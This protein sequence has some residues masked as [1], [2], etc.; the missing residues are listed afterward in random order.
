MKKQNLIFSVLSALM[1]CGQADALTITKATGWLESA[2]LTWQPVEN[3]EKYCVWYTDETAVARQIDMPLIRCYGAYYRADILGLKAGEYLFTVKAVDE[4]GNELESAV[5]APVAVLPHVREGFAF[6]DG[7]AEMVPGAYGSDGT[8]KP[9][10][11]VIYISAATVNTVTCDVINERGEAVPVTGL[12]NILSAR[13]RG[14][15]KTPLAIRMIGL[16]KS[17]QIDGLKG[18]NYIAFIGSNADKRMI[19]NITFEGVGNDATAYGYGFFTKRSKG[20]EIRNV[21][22]M[23][24]G[25]DGVSMEGDNFN[26]W[27]HNNDF[28]YGAPGSDKDQVKGDGSI[29]MKYNTTNITVSFNH[30]WDSGKTTFAGGAT[31]ENPIYFTYH[32]NWFDHSDSRHPRLCHATAHIYNN[33]FDGNKTMCLLNT[34]NSSAFV[35]ANHYRNCPY[36]MMINMQGTNRVIWPDGTQNGGMTKA[37]NNKIEGACTLVYQTDNADDFDAYLV[38]S[39]DEQIPAAVRSVTGGNV[40]S[41]FDTA[42]DMYA[43]TADDPEQVRTVVMAYAGRVEGGDLKWNFDND[44]DDVLTEVNT[45]LKDA[46]VGYESTLVSIQEEDAAGGSDPGEG[47]EKPVTDGF[48]GAICDMMSDATSS[49]SVTGGSTT[50]SKGSVTVDGVEYSCCLKM[51]SSTVVSFTTSAT[52][53]LTLFFAGSDGKKVEIDNGIGTFTV[54]NGIIEV[55]DLPAGSYTIKKKSGE[56]YLFYIRLSVNSLPTQLTGVETDYR[57]FVDRNVI[58]NDGNLY[59]QVYDMT[60]R[61]IYSGNKEAD[62]GAYPRG[63]YCVRVAE[64]GRTVKVAY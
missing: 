15:D 57:L 53:D 21:G 18:G 31:E 55:K 51:G 6:I 42:D 26:I 32:H 46:V 37:Y 39:R 56:S 49:V 58:R 12:M 43:Y 5:S 36:P 34:E 61:L 48:G 7:A 54:T 64:T 63:I 35:E 30:F 11:R 28:F 50:S 60:G 24:F 3:A 33:Y 59:I 62:L 20:L 10:A 8:L 4:E 38:S 16:I 9:G 25:D 23:L 52:T 19:E 14:Y 29:D 40:Y 44:T 41:N 47:E 1:I 2:A 17:S 22:I 45:P 13:G 27:V